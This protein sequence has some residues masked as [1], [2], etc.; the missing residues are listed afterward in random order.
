MLEYQAAKDLLNGKVILVTGAGD[1]IGK[2]AALTYA[3]HGATVILLGKT[4]KKLE[5]VYDLIEQ[6]GYP[7]PA[8]VPL[9]LKGAT[10]QNYV[11]MAETIEEQFGCL[12]G[13]LH[14]ASMLGVLGPFEHITMSS[15]EEVFKV[16]VIAE[17]MLTKALLPVMRK[18][19]SAS[20]IFTSSSVGRQARSFW[21][22]YAMSK[23]ATEGMMQAIAHEYEGSNIRSNSINP[24]AT[25]TGM[26]ANAYPAENPQSLKKPEE[27]MPTY[28]YLMG[29]DSADIN[30]QQLNAQ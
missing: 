18:S 8:I 27:I 9:D 29:K 11:D 20:L 15:V 12:D 21:G 22:E 1:G 14:N 3:Q 17:I 23:F 5:A 7:K 6:A 25:R 16:N 13:L 2:T 19:A 24:G 4:V 10:E 28:L 26:R 30:G